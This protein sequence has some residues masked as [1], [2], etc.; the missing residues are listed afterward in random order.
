MESYRRLGCHANSTVPSRSVS[1]IL[2][3][4]HPTMLWIPK[5]L[6][7]LVGG[8]GLTASSR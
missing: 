7:K 2:Q 3:A 4:A 1:L 8:G 6:G 5:M